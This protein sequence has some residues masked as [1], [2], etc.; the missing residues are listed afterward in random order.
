MSAPSSLL[1]SITKT[2]I[3]ILTTKTVSKGKHTR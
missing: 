3:A 1:V 2:M